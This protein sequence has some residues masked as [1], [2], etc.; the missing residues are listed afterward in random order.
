MTKLLKII[1]RTIGIML[2]WVLVLL[3]LFVFAIRSSSFQTYL[4]SVA[5]SYLSKEMNADIRIGKIDFVFINRLTL[6]DVFIADPNGDTLAK[7]GKIE[8]KLE[9]LDLAGNKVIIKEAVVHNGFIH[10]FREAKKG[11]YNYFFLID[12]FG[13]SK[14]STSKSEPMALTVKAVGLANIHFKYDDYRKGNSEYGIDFDH[15]DF[16]NVQ[17]MASELKTTKNGGL[18]FSM[19]HF[20]AFETSGFYLKQLSTFAEINPDRG[21]LLSKITIQTPKTTIYASKFNLRAKSFEAFQHFN[22]QVRFDA[23]I[24]SSVV[25]MKDVSFFATALEGM[26]Q[27]VRLSAELHQP[28]SQLQIQNVDLRF[29]RRTVVRGDFS[30]P[31]FSQLSSSH[32]SQQL[33]YALVDLSDVKA[34]HLP[35]SAGNKPLSFDPKI[36]R[37]GYAELTKL[38]VKG[39]ASNFFFSSKKISTALGTIHLDHGLHFNQLSEGG[40]SFKHT[41]N[42]AYDVK[43]DSFQLG[44]FLGDNMLGNVKG[45]FFLSGVVGQKD[46]IRFNELSGK[47]QQLGFNH[48]NYTSIVVSNGSFINNKFISKIDVNDPHLKMN[49]N[50]TLDLNKKQKF[51]IDL[52]CD[53]A[54]L[55]ILGFSTDKESKLIAKLETH[56]TMTNIDD[57]AGTVNAH[58]INFQ[59]NQKNYSLQN[60]DL[61]ITRGVEDQLKLYSDLIDIEGNGKVTSGNFVALLNNSFSKLLPA[62]IPEMPVSKKAKPEYLTVHSTLNETKDIL[63]IFYPELAISYGTTIDFTYNS[64]TDIQTLGLK[65]SQITLFGTEDRDTSNQRYFSNL[66]L[67]DTLYSGNLKLNLFAEKGSIDDSLFV[68]DFTVTANGHQG[69]FSS[70]TEWNKK[71][72]DESARFVFLAD[73][74]DTAKTKLT[75]KPSEFHLKGKLWEI[76]NTARVTLESSKIDINHLT[77]E[78]DEQFL[79]LNGLI[80]PDDRDVLKCNINNVNLAEF[81]SFISSDLTVSGLLN[82]QI[83]L[84]K[85]YTTPQGQGKISINKLFIDETKIGDL[86]IGGNWNPKINAFIFEPGSELAYEEDKS[87]GIEGRLFPLKDHDNYNIRLNFNNTDLKFLNGFMDPTVVSDIAGSLKGKLF[88]SGDFIAPRINGNLT[89]LQGGAKIGILGTTYNFK[90]GKIEFSDSKGMITANIPTFD[91]ENNR[92]LIKAVVK[93]SD[94]TGFNVKT[95]V[96]FNQEKVENFTGKFMVLNTPYK[97][98]EIYYGK[99]YAHGNA[100]IGIVNDIVKIDVEATTN[101]GTDITLPMYGASD[102]SDFPF[103]TFGEAK[104]ADPRLNLSG[105]EMK[106]VVHATPDAKMKLDFNPKTGDAISVAGHTAV[107]GLSIEIH[108]NNSIEMNGEYVF[109]AGQYHFVLPPYEKDFKLKKGGNIKWTGS[110]YDA[111]M[112]IT[113]F[114]P[115]GVDYS[116]LTGDNSGSLGFGEVNLGLKIEDKLSKPKVILTIEPNNPTSE[117]QTVLRRAIQT[118]EETQKQWFSV[119]AFKKFAPLNGENHGG[120]GAV[121][122]LLLDKINDQLKGKLGGNVDMGLQNN[123][124]STNTQTSLNTN[125]QVNDKITIKTAVGV[126]TSQAGESSTSSV[127]GDV[128]VEYKINDDGSFRLVIFNEAGNKSDVTS[129]TGSELVQGVTLSYNSEFNNPGDRKRRKT[130]KKKKNNKIIPIEPVATK[131]DENDNKHTVGTSKN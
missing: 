80:S 51:D 66:V 31:D 20:T 32:F 75:V 53:R 37:L 120:A 11:D 9:E 87:L 25:N 84:Q 58:A 28:L 26:D 93:H 47:I 91:Q 34:L 56:L 88:V 107:D 99:A 39:S 22:D 4:G 55:G 67:N 19:D 128:S 109:D 97:E 105:V 13:S 116:D 16:K 124:G 83:E 126:Q 46:V 12:Y 38:N 41:N 82:G 1:G 49:F 30:L 6:K 123:S 96:L 52:S 64:A 18:K 70:V 48:Y 42:S 86:T 101:E 114:V 115:V 110:P 106:L 73:L 121:T 3:I 62:Y 71:T 125:I 7:V 131:P 112:D 81:S 60:L 21:V 61:S 76:Q 94:F 50:G 74:K 72:V 8:V 117:E 127:V 17:M 122:D 98:G 10:I 89:L 92:A 40:Y 36:E 85:L 24:D 23:V 111:K 103:I 43:V 108:Q 130:N 113:A 44:K 78:R 45:D 104:A 2:E 77:I 33:D 27:D 102:I 65:S 29:G 63:A 15:L 79:S 14:K 68:N 54:D 119:F 5:T 90:E 100:S 118:T 129:S 59:Q 95:D 35:K 69:V 57:L